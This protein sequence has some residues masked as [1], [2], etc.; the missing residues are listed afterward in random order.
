MCVSL[1][2]CWYTD[3]A[4]KRDK[5]I[6]QEGYKMTLE[7]RLQ[8]MRERNE[9]ELRFIRVEALQYRVEDMLNYINAG[10]DNAAQYAARCAA[11]WAFSL[12]PHLREDAAPE[13]KNNQE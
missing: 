8:A 7:D 12:C 9:S 3:I 6:G 10:Y 11:G 1:A 4:S 13:E 5:A 2:I